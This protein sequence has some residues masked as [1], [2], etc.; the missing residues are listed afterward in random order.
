MSVYSQIR[1]ER[2]D[3]RKEANNLRRLLGQ[4][5]EAADAARQAINR[6]A[7]QEGLSLA[8]ACSKLGDFVENA[9]APM[10]ADAWNS[11]RVWMAGQA[12]DAMTQRR[13]MEAELLK[14]GGEDAVRR[15]MAAAEAE[16]AARRTA[17]S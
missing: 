15:A 6:S 10:D 16:I 9:K 11:Q 3:A 5:R 7:W 8:E 17:K 12:L 13:H 4:A 1:R 14:I 2:D